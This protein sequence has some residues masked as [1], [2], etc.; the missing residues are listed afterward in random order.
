[1]IALIVLHAFDGYNVGETITDPELVEAVSSGSK[2]QLVVRATL[3]DPEPETEADKKPKAD[4]IPVVDKTAPV[5]TKR[6]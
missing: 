6:G 4:F 5:D 1:M 2:A 3:P